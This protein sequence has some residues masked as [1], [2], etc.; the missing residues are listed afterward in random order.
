MGPKPSSS[1]NNLN[2]AQIMSRP[3][4]QPYVPGN[5]AVGD[6]FQGYDN[7]Q[8]N[9]EN[10]SNMGENDLNTFSGGKY[11]FDPDA[12]YYLTNMSIQEAESRFTQSEVSQIK[13]EFDKNSK[14]QII[15][16]RKLIEYFKITE[17]S[18]TYLANEIFSII[19]NS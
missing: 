15:G 4:I 17:I 7:T 5:Q 19:K 13:R 8:I 16:K 14:D 6:D 9:Q 2:D 11:N 10:R 12:L 1:K 3:T 18:E